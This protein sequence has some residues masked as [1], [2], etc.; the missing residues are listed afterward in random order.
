MSDIS[1]EELAKWRAA[2]RD[3]VLLDVREHAEV[4]RASFAGALH[5]PLRELP[6][7]LSS[8]RADADIAVICH[9]GGRSEYA[10]ALLRAHGFSR[11]HNVEGGIDAYAERVDASIPRY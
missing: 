6:A 11:V 1:V 2:G 8:V 10:A 5:I 4:A 7:R 9:Y 3:F